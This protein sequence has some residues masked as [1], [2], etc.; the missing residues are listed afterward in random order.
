MLCV[1]GCKLKRWHIAAAAAAVSVGRAHHRRACSE[2]ER[3][4]GSGRSV[5]ERDVRWRYECCRLERQRRGDAATDDA[6]SRPTSL[7]RTALLCHARQYHLLHFYSSLLI[8]FVSLADKCYRQG[9]QTGQGK[10]SSALN[11]LSHASFFVILLNVNAV[12][13]VLWCCW[14]GG[15]KGIQPV[16]KLIGGVLAWLSVWSEVQPCIWPSWCH[17]QS[18]SLASVKSRLVLPFW[19]RLTWVVPDKGPLNG[20]VGVCVC[21]LNVNATFYC[22]PHFFHVAPTK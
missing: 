17:C 6:L 15:K 21:V 10:Y 16:K 9:R 18:L 12:P 7:A 3:R 11:A 1:A 13:S 8:V 4:G 14:L 19:Y 2:R 20:C 5:E 22:R